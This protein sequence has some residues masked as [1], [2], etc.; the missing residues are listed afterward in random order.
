MS[1][2]KKRRSAKGSFDRCGGRLKKLFEKSF[3]RIIKNFSAA[4]V[5]YLIKNFRAQQE[6]SP[7]FSRSVRL[8]RFSYGKRRCSAAETESAFAVG[9][10]I[11]I[12][13]KADRSLHQNNKT[14]RQSGEFCCFISYSKSLP[15][16]TSLAYFS[17]AAFS[18]LAKSASALSGNCCARRL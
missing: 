7:S 4:V 10:Y 8:W 3:L 17:L 2:K 16:L 5:F 1:I 18:A 14:H 13:P 12:P 15:Y 9:K 11:I 6:N